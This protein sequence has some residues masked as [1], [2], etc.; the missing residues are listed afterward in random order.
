MGI[1]PCQSNGAFSLQ[2]CSIVVPIS[3]TCLPIPVCTA[4]WSGWRQNSNQLFSL[5]TEQVQ[6]LSAALIHPEMVQENEA[7][8][9]SLNTY[10][11]P[12]AIPNGLASQVTVH[13]PAIWLYILCAIAQSVLCFHL[14][15]GH[16]D[17]SHWI[18][19]LK[20]HDCFCILEV[21]QFTILT[22]TAWW[23]KP[24]LA[25]CC[26]M[27]LFRAQFH[28]SSGQT[29]FQARSS[30]QTDWSSSLGYWTQWVTHEAQLLAVSVL[31]P[32]QL[33][34]LDIAFAAERCLIP[35]SPFS[36]NSL[37]STDKRCWIHLLAKSV[38]S[39]SLAP[40]RVHPN[41]YRMTYFL[42]HQTPGVADWPLGLSFDLND[43]IS[44]LL[45]VSFGRGCHVI[46]I[47]MEGRHGE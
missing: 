39:H 25:D 30:L 24:M 17:S 35:A 13:Q 46:C 3:L 11:A 7:R 38:N 34:V 21:P 44:S 12:V 45:F 4:T 20:C 18:W 28:W 2:L 22:C 33:P 1:W 15:G 41:A 43:L 8:R 31:W 14:I 36:L 27:L 10:C 6:F 19:I 16:N 42:R 29:G 47:S 32:P 26:W 37:P 5:S 40:L 23:M 9:L